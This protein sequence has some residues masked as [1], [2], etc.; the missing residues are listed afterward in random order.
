MQFQL[1]IQIK[2]PETQ[3]NYR[4]KILLTGSCF[5]EHIGNSLG[6]LKFSVLQN[7]N[8]ILF[9]PRSVCCSL[10]SYIE[11][12]KY[13]KEDLFLLNEVWNSWEHH[14]RFSK[15]NADECLKTINESQQQ[16]HNFLKDADWLIITLGSAFSYRITNE[17]LPGGL[18][19]NDGVANCHRAPSQWF[20]KHLLS[21]DETISLLDGAYHRLKQFN[22]KLKIIFTISPVRHI[23]DGVIEN[24]RSKA[25]LIEAVHHVINKFPGLYYFPAYELVIDVLRDYRYYDIDMVHPNYPATEFVMEKFRE[26]FIDE[27]SQQLME[28]IKKI[29]IARKHKAFQP[30]TNAHKAFLKTHLEKTKELQTKFSFLDLSDEINYFTSF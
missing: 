26:N 21:I 30:E 24:N 17:A 23:R 15:I 13:G 10:I 19:N 9:D 4:D 14:S 8:G 2:P 1:P 12:K 25:R 22:P 6:D 18:Q 28:E 20:N 29:V 11:N 27:Q 7:P 5:T 3:I 16:A